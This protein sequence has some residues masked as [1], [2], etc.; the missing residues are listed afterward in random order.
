M[1]EPDLQMLATPG[2]F[3]V[4][5]RP[6]GNRCLLTS[7]YGVTIARDARGFVVAK[8]ASFLPGGHPAAAQEED[9]ELEK[10]KQHWM[11]ADEDMA[12]LECIFNKQTRTYFVVDI[13]H[14]GDTSYR[15][16]PLAVRLHHLQDKFQQL[17]KSGIAAEFNLNFRLVDYLDC[18]VEAFN[19]CYY[20]PLLTPYLTRTDQGDQVI[21]KQAVF[22]DLSDG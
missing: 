16:Y 18:T 2:A 9:E 11:G 22:R 20:G 1:L 10:P 7:G 13:M 21:D 17:A 5:A 19:H 15:Q 6:E 8:F 4:Y 3:K 12:A 14:W